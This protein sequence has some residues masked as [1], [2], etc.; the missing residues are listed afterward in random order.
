MIKKSEQELQK[1]YDA[2][3]VVMFRPKHLIVRDQHNRKRLVKVVNNRGLWP[4]GSIGIDQYYDRN[5]AA[6]K[7]VSLE[8][9]QKM[10]GYFDGQ[11]LG[12]DNIKYFEES[13]K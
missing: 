7:R 9:L 1:M 2:Y 12:A 6:F 5:Y 8:E 13:F 11:K 10:D 3:S 4:D